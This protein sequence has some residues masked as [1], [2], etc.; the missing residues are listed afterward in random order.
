M[1]QFEPNDT[2]MAEASSTGL[3][4]TLDLAGQVAIMARYQ[5]QV[6]VFRATVPLGAR[7][8]RL[9]AEENFIDR[10]G[11]RKAEGAGVPPRRWLTTPRSSA[12]SSIDIAGTL[13]TASDV[14]AFLARQGPGQ[15]GRSWSTACSTA[16]STPTIS[17]T[18][19][20]CS[21]Q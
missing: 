10:A 8:D 13:P 6:A 5:G 20:T 18:S 11:F 14:T 4:K 21:A 15:A 17:P 3:V 12:A 9:P 16:P 7:V 1:A 2:E 19:G